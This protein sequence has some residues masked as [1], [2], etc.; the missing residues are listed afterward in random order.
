MEAGPRRGEV[1]MCS[2]VLG[3]G[4]TTSGA[5]RFILGARRLT[6]GMALGGEEWDSSRSLCYAT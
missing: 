5:L 1:M 3:S 4:Q 6:N 2:P